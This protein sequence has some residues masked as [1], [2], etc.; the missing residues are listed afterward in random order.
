MISYFVLFR[1]ISQEISR[2][3]SRGGHPNASLRS[4]L[5]STNIEQ[6][7]LDHIT[8]LRRPARPH[9]LVPKKL[10]QSNMLN[11]LYDSSSYSSSQYAQ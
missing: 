5:A 11:L 10:T 4:L 6:K 9:D 2:L 7:A 8:G 1:I 3:V